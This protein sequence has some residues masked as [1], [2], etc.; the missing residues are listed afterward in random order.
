MA[1]M[2]RA[3][4]FGNLVYS[5]QGESITIT[6][7]VS[8]PT[9]PVEIPEEIDGKPVTAIGNFAFS[10]CEKMPSVVIPDSVT[11]IGDWAFQVCSSLESV[12]IPGSVDVIG[13]RAFEDCSALTNLEFGHGVAKI[14]V[15]SFRGCVGLKSLTLPASLKYLH[16]SAFDDCTNLQVM[17]FLGNAPE[18]AT[19]RFNGL[20]PSFKVRYYEGRKG[21][22]TNEGYWKGVPAEM[23]LLRPEIQVEQPLG[24]TVG[25]E[26]QDERALGRLEVGSRSKPM[27]FT[28]R[29]LGEE[30]LTGM[31][32]KVT[33]AHAK[34]FIVLGERKTLAGR[35][36]MKFRVIFKPSAVGPRQAMLRIH[37]DDA[38]EPTVKVRL[39]GA[40][41]KKRVW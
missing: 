32:L 1:V 40:G 2:A 36:S 26:W 30:A 29:N 13:S 39:A 28:I 25:E 22:K 27:Y 11:S 18:V 24:T 33:G 41:R 15:A 37:S 38:D 4:Q 21:F 20:P 3:G 16:D 5:D 12:T 9:E 8:R 34:D 7:V 6:G 14:W 35:A 31:A 10:Y 17:T 23:I 19:M